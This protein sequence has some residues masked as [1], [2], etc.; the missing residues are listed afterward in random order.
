MARYRF[1]VENSLP[2]VPT[3]PEIREH[4]AGA[5][6]ACWCRLDETCHADVLLEVANR[7]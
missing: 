7:A 4:L 6:L 3:V 1:A 2:D 5:D